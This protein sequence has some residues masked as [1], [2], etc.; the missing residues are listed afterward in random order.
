MD[1]K[2][3]RDNL[4]RRYE[5]ARDA[6]CKKFSAGVASESAYQESAKNL[7]EL[8]TELREVSEQLG[9]PMPIWF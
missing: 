4:K 2:E 7:M 5:N 8:H 9:E 1:L 3:K 6:H